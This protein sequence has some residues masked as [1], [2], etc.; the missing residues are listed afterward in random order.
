MLD[1]TKP[2]QSDKIKNEIKCDCCNKIIA[3][4]KDGIIY[5]WCK[6]CKKEIPL[7]IQKVEP[8]SR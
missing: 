8:L 7:K 3:K 4:E 1:L 6:H 5:L 2:K